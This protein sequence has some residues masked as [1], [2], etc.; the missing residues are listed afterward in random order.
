VFLGSH[1]GKFILTSHYGC[2]PSLKAN[3][4][5]GPLHIELDDDW[6]LC[7]YSLNMREW[8]WMLEPFILEFTFA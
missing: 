7:I 6:I 8:F 5:C 1:E 4:L 3:L 2:D